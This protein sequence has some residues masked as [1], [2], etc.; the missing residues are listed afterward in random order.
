MYDEPWEVVARLSTAPI[1]APHSGRDK[2][3]FGLG[4]NHDNGSD[5]P[6]K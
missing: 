1:V 2:G 4:S 3:H 6:G 5:Q